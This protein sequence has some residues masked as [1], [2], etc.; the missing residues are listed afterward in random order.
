MDLLQNQ[1]RII[2]IY[3]VIKIERHLTDSG[4]PVSWLENNHVLSIFSL[5]SQDKKNA[6]RKNHHKI[7]EAATATGCQN[8]LL[9]TIRQG[10]QTLKSTN[11]V[12]LKP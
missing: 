7:S 2:M 10:A 8:A 12:F 9:L 5:N 4:L 6:T 3:K 11:S 1:I